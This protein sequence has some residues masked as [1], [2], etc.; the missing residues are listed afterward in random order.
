MEDKS[1]R[2]E[3]KQSIDSFLGMVAIIISGLVLPL[4]L[5]LVV[6]FTGFSEIIEEISKALIVS[7]LILGFLSFRQKVA[8]GISF[9][10]L[11]ALSENL[12]YFNNIFQTGNFAVLWQRFFLTMPMHIITVLVILFSGLKSKK[13]IIL[14]TLG[15][16]I[17]HLLFNHFIT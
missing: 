9:G 3:Q 2:F 8:A 6:K 7:F 5:V 16:I 1:I 4:I 10:F 14:G 11:F 17:I 15:A 13:Y 12:L